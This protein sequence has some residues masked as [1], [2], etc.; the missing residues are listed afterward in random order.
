MQGQVPQHPF[1]SRKVREEWVKD[2]IQVPDEK[3]KQYYVDWQRRREGPNINPYYPT[4]QIAC[5]WVDWMERMHYIDDSLGMCAG[6]SSWPQKPPYHLNNYPRVI[7]AA[8]GIEYDMPKLIQTTRRIRSLLRAINNRRG[9]RRKDDKM[10]EEFKEQRVQQAD[11]QLEVD[12]LDG[13]YQTKGWN[14]EGIPTQESLHELG[15]DYVAKDLIERGI[16][17]ESEDPFPGQTT[18]DEHKD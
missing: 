11:E 12:L 8:T 9:I 14:K 10:P 5:E 6:Q 4:V 2:W 7:T 3:F 17:M 15:L 18:A 1:S 16:L 13:W